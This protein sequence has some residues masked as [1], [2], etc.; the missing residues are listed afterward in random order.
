MCAK[1]LILAILSN[2]LFDKQHHALLDYVTLY[3]KAMLGNW[4]NRVAVLC[5][6]KCLLRAKRSGFEKWPNVQKK[7]KEVGLN[8]Y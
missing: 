3:Y 2:T 8:L 1:H 6:C 5:Q 4:G 7:S